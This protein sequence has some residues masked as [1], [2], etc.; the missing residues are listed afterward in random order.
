MIMLLSVERKLSVCFKT[1][2]GGEQSDGNKG[3]GGGSFGVVAA[4]IINL[5]MYWLMFVLI[6]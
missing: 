3:N 4:V 1:S 2:N 6:Y 5:L